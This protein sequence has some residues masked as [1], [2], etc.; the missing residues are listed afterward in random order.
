MKK[1]HIIGIIVI[2]VSIGFILSSLFEAST[3]ASFGEAFEND[4]KEYHVV[5]SLDTSHD[6]VYDPM[7]DPNLT[8][9]HMKDEQGVSR[10]VKLFKS[11]PQDFE[12][13][14]TIVLIGKAVGDDFHANDILMKCP[15]KYEEGSSV[16]ASLNP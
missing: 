8:V 3:Y 11:K 5:G 9:F 16:E 4:G 1:S 6:V 12:K 7:A 10:K 14:E 13:T 15:S 2:A